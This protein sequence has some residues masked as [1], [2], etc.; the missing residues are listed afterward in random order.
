[1]QRSELINLIIKKKKQLIIINMMAVLMSFIL[2]YLLPKKWEVNCIVAPPTSNAAVI[3]TANGLATRLRSSSTLSAVIKDLNSSVA[4]NYTYSELR[5]ELK[6]SVVDKIVEIRIVSKSPIIARA[7]AISLLE[8]V[9]TQ[10]ELYLK[11]VEDI[12]KTVRNDIKNDF[13]RFNILNSSELLHMAWINANV[14]LLN[15]VNTSAKS[16]FIVP[17]DYDQTPSEPKFI[18]LFALCL[19]LSLLISFIIL[20]ETSA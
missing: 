18:Q 12:Q 8:Q 6:V 19:C 2:F 5:S 14:G 11:S 7:V 1:M 15:V 20:N 3:D 9:N 17:P 16:V 4:P 13:R 10:E